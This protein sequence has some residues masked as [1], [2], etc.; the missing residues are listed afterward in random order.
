[1]H[2]YPQTLVPPL[3]LH[4]VPESFRPAAQI[5]PG[6]PA[7]ERRKAMRKAHR[8]SRIAFLHLLIPKRKEL[9]GGPPPSAQLFTSS[10]PF[11]PGPFP[12]CRPGKTRT[13]CGGK[14]LRTI[15]LRH[16]LR[17][18]L[19]HLLRHEHVGTMQLKPASE[20]Q[21]TPSGPPTIRSY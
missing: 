5:S 7:D 13:L 14:K 12:P 6:P 17:H 19:R 3:L 10:F 20:K 4:Q 9:S 2:D 11:L 8:A 18:F 15:F 1:M 21:S 16:L